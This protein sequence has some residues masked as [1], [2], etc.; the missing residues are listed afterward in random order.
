MNSTA[1]PVS[2]SSSGN[3]AKARKKRSKKRGSQTV[4]AS[5]FSAALN[6]SASNGGNLNVI[7]VPAHAR[8]FSAPVI[9]GSA[10][11]SSSQTQAQ[12]TDAKP[13]LRASS[14]SGTVSTRAAASAWACGCRLRCCTVWPSST[15][16]VNSIPFLLDR[17]WCIRGSIIWPSYSRQ[18]TGHKL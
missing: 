15:V 8:Q 11:G 7:G 12:N 4:P 13:V 6:A 9:A 17:F 14:Y 2:A 16:I 1:A 5:V 3:S 10:S 18:I